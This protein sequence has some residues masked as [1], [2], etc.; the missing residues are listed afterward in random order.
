VTLP[1]ESLEFWYSQ[2]EQRKV[3]SMVRE[4]TGL[5]RK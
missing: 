5:L 3:E 2:A 1:A 4:V